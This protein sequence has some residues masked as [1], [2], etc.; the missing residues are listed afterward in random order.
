[1]KKWVLLSCGLL[2]LL[3]TLLSLPYLIEGPNLQARVLGYMEQSL[4]VKA[5][6]QGVGWRWLPLPAITITR[7]RA[8]SDI[9][10]LEVSTADLV[11]NPVFFLSGTWPLLSARLVNPDLLLKQSSHPLTSIPGGH[12][13]IVNGTL[14]LPARDLGHGLTLAPITLTGLKGG[15][16]SS[17]H[18]L[19]LKISGTADWAKTFAVSAKVNLD[20]DGIYQADFS[21]EG[22][23][24]SRLVSQPRT[25][26][27][28]LPAL[29]G[30]RPG[31]HLQGL[32]P[33]R[34]QLRGEG[35]GTPFTMQVRDQ[36]FKV[37][38][39]GGFTVNSDH[40]DLSLDIDNLVLS[41]PRLR[42]SGRVARRRAPQ[43]SDSPPEWA[44][45]LSGADLDLGAIRTSVLA[46]FG[47]NPITQEVC[48]I[49]RG[50]E[51]TTARYT[52]S[53]GGGDFHHLR[54]MKIWAEAKDVPVTLPHLGLSLDRA[55][56]PIAI[57]NDRLT[58]KGLS[59][60][61]DNSHGENGSL[62]LDLGKDH[63]GFNLDLDLDADLINLHDVLAK[64]TPSP[65]F[66]DELKHFVGVRGRA[67]GHLRLGDDLH[68]IKTEVDVEAVQAKGTYDRLPWPFTITAGSLRIAPQHLEWDGVQGRLGDQRVSNSQGG[69]DWQDAILVTING[70]DADLDLQPLF[71]A[72][73]LRTNSATIA[74]R[75][76]IH[77]RFD[78]VS[79]HARLSDTLFSGP[80]L[81]PEQWQYQT[82][83][84]CRDLGIGGTWLPVLH[85]RDVEA[86][87][88]EQQADFTGIF[89]LLD[90]ELFLSGHYQ[91]T[92]FDKWHGDLEINGDIGRRLGEWFRDKN[93]VPAAT[94]PRLPFR[95]EK[96]IVTNPHPGFASFL[97]H[98]TLV[99]HQDPGVLAQVNLSREP[100]QIVNTLTFQNRA[101]TGSL[102]YSLW[103]RQ[104]NRSQLTWQG[105]LDVETLDALFTQ[106]L[107]QGGEI[108]GAF[109][110]LTD[111]AATLYSGSVE[112]SGVRFLPES[113]IPDLSIATLHLQGDNSGITVNHADLALAGVPATVAGGVSETAGLHTLD[114]RLTAPKLS[115]ESI[116]KVVE[117]VTE[118]RAPSEQ[119]KS[120][121]DS[122]R[123]AI[124]FDI[125]AFDYIRPPQ[126]QEAIEG[127]EQDHAFIAVPFVGRVNFDP[128][129]IGIEI[130]KSRVC[131][132]GVQGIWH[133]NGESRVDQVLF[134]SGG[135]PLSFEKALPCLGVEQSLI[136][137]PFAIEGQISGHPKHW[138]QGTL[139]LTSREGLIKR[140]NLLSMIF[141]AV[142]VTDYFTWN[143]LPNMEEEGLA[144]NDLVLNAHIDNNTLVLDRTVVKGKGVN[145]SGRGT[146]NLSDLN[147]DLT[148][149]I[150]P[151]KT[152][153]SV[154][155]NIPLIGKAL[156]GPKESILTFPVTVT[157]NIKSPEVTALA[158]QAIGSATLELL[159]DALTLPF[160]IFQ[161][162][163]GSST[164]KK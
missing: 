71:E 119:G 115:W 32:G 61:I 76:L 145:L 86:K 151:L 117:R 70:L 113:L 81:N 28:L 44:L 57:I 7:L 8:E 83:V 60:T 23:D 94:F 50:G 11:V 41:E 40:G 134:S 29:R 56:G 38:D 46:L 51:A 130:D 93:L 5:S 97:A 31:L 68:Q 45:D 37:K 150:A 147:S 9:F 78:T 12:L 19:R 98:G 160:R 55:S 91:H 24:S 10:T 121:L 79:G 112:A 21:G 111:H 132:I 49:V 17:T 142:N 88:S 18:A 154:V 2:L 43:K 47:K 158:P 13:G 53:G 133:L 33:G 54:S 96:C 62:L 107:L 161:P 58:G 155:S 135:T 146:V 42:L 84:H 67:Q 139:S 63:H 109:S 3:A 65:K 77:G 66:Q 152:L 114:L 131:G 80:I 30:L 87:I 123:G 149:F 59:A 92:F 90:Q 140:M 157:G 4:R 75:D 89:N 144:Y 95:L 124:A 64:I 26:G 48:A 143:D 20:H 34:F 102:S 164:P 101:R 27:S 6:A 105:E 22:V 14:R 138:Q 153:D 162:D 104:G 127:R 25:E 156:A 120:A 141:T 118:K 69:V 15:V 108:A 99:S 128:P 163:K 159:R 72:G 1:M 103:P 148:F 74:I 136:I 39:V 100:D 85:S 16:T 82:M 36:L 106:H 125:G 116:R 52:F 35:R 122:L 110:R 129:G 73:T 137:G 126:N